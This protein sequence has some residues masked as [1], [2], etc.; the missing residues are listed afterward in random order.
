MARGCEA[1]T[2]VLPSAPVSSLATT[3]HDYFSQSARFTRVPVSTVKHC[4]T[5]EVSINDP[6]PV[7]TADHAYHLAIISPA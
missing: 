7:H 6:S 1:W 4:P 3:R 2:V 5:T